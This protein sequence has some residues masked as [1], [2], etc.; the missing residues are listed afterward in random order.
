MGGICQ[1]GG[2]GFV[3]LVCAPVEVSLSGALSFPLHDLK[4]LV[5]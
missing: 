4:I 2:G 3:F 5:G 1:K